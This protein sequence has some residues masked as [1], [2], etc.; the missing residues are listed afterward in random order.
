MSGEDGGRDVSR[1]AGR[2]GREAAGRQAASR[3]EAPG[4]GARTLARALEVPALLLVPAA[5]L[6]CA[7][8]QIDAAGGLVLATV[9]LSL[10][11]FCASYEA[12]RPT[13]RQV[14]PTATLGAVAAAGRILFAPLPDV[15]PVSA[16]AIT[17]GATLGRRSGFLV[18]AIAALVSNLFFGQGAWTP[19]QM[20]AWGLVGY[21]SGVLADLGAF[22]PPEAAEGRAR[23]GQV[24]AA[25]TTAATEPATPSS[26]SQTAPAPTSVA[27]ASAS[28]RVPASLL[29]WGFASGLL[30]GLL[31][32]SWYVLG[33]VRPL[34]WQPVLAAFAA[35]LPLDV[36]HGAATAGFLAL[37]WVP[38]GRSIRR[39]VAT[40][41]LAGE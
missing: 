23:D 16:I 11:L 24:P 25:R 13:L 29:V 10:L 30:Y 27:Q 40:Y 28:R 12:S 6:W 39:V 4:G 32:N 2:S 18:G 33:Y 20:Y 21:L 22:G 5:M 35:G 19:M 41:G 37:I 17:A 3:H 15:K 8:R 14:V 9:A 36:V 7:W 38:W 31:L 34:A 26:A 1:Q